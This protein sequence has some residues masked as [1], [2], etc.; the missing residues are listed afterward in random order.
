MN[1]P[2]HWR[3]P[4]AEHDQ[5]PD[6][7]AATDRRPCRW[8]LIACVVLLAS[9]ADRAAAAPGL[10]HR[11]AGEAQTVRD[12]LPIVELAAGRSRGKAVVAS[13]AAGDHAAGAGHRHLRAHQRLSEDALRRHRRPRE[14]GPAAG[15]DRD[16]RG[17]S[18]A[19]PGARDAR[20]RARPT[21]SSCRRISIWRGRPCKRYVA[22]GVGER[23]AAADRRRARR[24][25]RSP[26]R[27]STRRARPSTRSQSNV[28]R[29]TA[30]AGLPARLRAVR[31]HHH[32]SATSTTARSSR[33]ARRRARPSSSR[34]SQVDS[35]RIFVYVPQAYAADVHVGAGGRRR[36][37]PGFPDRVFHGTVTRTAGAIDPA[38]RTLLTEVQVPNQRW[39]AALR[40]LRHGALQAE[41]R[42]PAAADP[43]HGVADR[44]PRLARR[45]DRR[46]PDAALQDG[47]D[48]P[49]LRHQVEVLRGLSTA[50]DVIAPSAARRPVAEG[51]HV[52]IAA[53]REPRRAMRRPPHS[54]CCCSPAAAAA[55]WS[56]R[57][58]IHR[59]STSPP[60]WGEL[61]PSTQRPATPARRLASAAT[62]T[63]SRSGGRC[64]GSP[65]ERADPLGR[66]RPTSTC[67][68]AADRIRQARALRT[69]A[70]GPLWPNVGD[71]EQLCARAQQRQHARPRRTT[72]ARRSTSTRSASTRAGSSTSSA[73]IV[74]RWRRPRRQPAGGAGR[75][76]RRCWS[77]CSARSPATT[78]PTAALQQRIAIANDNVKS[79]KNT[80]ALTRRLFAAGL[81]T[82][83]D[84][85]RAESQVATTDAT[86]PLLTAQARR[87]SCT[88]S[89]CCSASRR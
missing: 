48:R 20:A 55:A 75:T 24:R 19:E 74:A 71:A 14:G 60:A 52:Q 61:S 69:I 25:S 28:D 82:D 53:E 84:V 15:R 67:E 65:A 31:R 66:V 62:P 5:A 83:L 43:R 3:S 33:P 8:S 17:G 58:T 7:A 47:R 18:G 27:R 29:L 36:R 40:R 81:A 21:S 37:A 13:A 46:R 80:L 16:A 10:W 86:I 11:L 12:A 57:T 2:S 38:S 85:A 51:A 26:T 42:E 76:G 59:S 68:Q 70:G 22:A 9:G 4:P 1:A 23:L 30:A 73:A 64:S 89:A 49:R 72:S 41:P 50:S 63:S 77:R 79:Q 56:D 87:R 45:R 34:L 35:L 88:C 44:R 78:S 39:R 32:R 54:G 6:A